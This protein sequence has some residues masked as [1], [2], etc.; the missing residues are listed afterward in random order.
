MGYNVTNYMPITIAQELWDT[1]CNFSHINLM[2]KIN[3]F[4]CILGGTSQAEIGHFCTQKSEA[5]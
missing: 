2:A 1:L 4:S 3:Y 5:N